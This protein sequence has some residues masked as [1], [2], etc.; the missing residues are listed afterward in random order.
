MDKKFVRILGWSACVA[1]VC[2]TVWFLCAFFGNPLSASLSRASA[3]RFLKENFS[4]TDYEIVDSGF[5]MKTG[6]YYVD[7][8]CP[9]SPDSHFI[10]YCD[11]LGRYRANTYEDVTSGYN[12]FSRLNSEYW[13]LVKENL[14]YDLF[15]I[16]IGFGDLRASG[17]FEVF[18]YTGENGEV[19]EYTFWKD[20][21]L[22][23]TSLVLDGEYDIRE[24][25][26]NHGSI[27]LYIHDT[28]VSVERAAE[29]L[30]AVKN[31]LDEQGVP[32]HAIEFHLCEPR[33]E[34]GQNVGRQI[35]LHEF[36]YSEI[37]EEGLIDRVRDYWNAAQ[38]HSAIQNGE[39]VNSELIYLE[40]FI[41]PEK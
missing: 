11:G 21:G 14:P 7:V 40:E 36:P 6:E 20:Y 28:D 17:Y 39:K 32:F 33:N 13:Y 19:K 31:H 16:S 25:G 29:L 9:G 23:M 24:L 12:T 2:F 5:D 15:D 38:E 41:V 10:I 27:C 35:T 26:R 4:G 37:C 22:D 34:Q 30:L 3:D 1:L 18:S 8:L